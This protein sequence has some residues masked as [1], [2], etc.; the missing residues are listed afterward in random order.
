MTDGKEVQD[1]T[2]RD[3]CSVFPQ[4]QCSNGK[5]N[6]VKLLM[7]VHGSHGL[8]LSQTSNNHKESDEARGPK[9]NR[10]LM[11]GVATDIQTHASN[12]IT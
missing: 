6:Q 8:G 4:G 10:L 7:F 5:P 12:Y 3:E 11:Y 1:G 2:T 9:H